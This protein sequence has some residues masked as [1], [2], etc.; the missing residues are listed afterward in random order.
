MN[1]QIECPACQRRFQVNDDLTGKTVEC[2]ACDHRFAVTEDM[3][4]QERKK[5]YPG[6]Q[7]GEGLDHFGRAP[8]RDDV[9]VTFQT[10]QYTQGMDAEVVQPTSPIQIFASLVGVAI[11][12]VFGLFFLLATRDGGV[13]NDVDLL[14][15]F[16]LGGFISMIGCGLLVFGAKGW[17]GRAIGIAIALML[18]LLAIIWVSPVN[19]TPTTY[20]GLREPFKEAEKATVGSSEL[21]DVEEYLSDIGYAKVVDFINK[22]TDLEKGINGLDHVVAI[23]AH[24]VSDIAFNTLE[25]HLR[26]RLSLAPNIPIHNYKRNDIKDRL[27]VISGPM[28]NLEVVARACDEAGEVT[29]LTKRRLLDLSINLTS[30]AN[31]KP[32]EMEK[33]KNPEHEI[34]C[35]ANLGELDNIQ[36]DRRKGAVDRLAL[37]PDDMKKRYKSAIAQKLSEMVATESDEDLIKSAGSALQ[38]WGVG[39]ATIVKSVGKAVAEKLEDEQSIPKSIVEY[40]ILAKSDQALLA[41]DQQWAR[42]PTRWSDQYERLGSLGEDRLAFHIKNSPVELRNS[43]VDI[44]RRVGTEKSIPTLRS[45][46]TGANDGFDI[47]LKRAIESIQSR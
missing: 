39:E 2:G 23:Y 32:E 37:V 36:L 26:R 34:F 3:T 10:A 25:E 24:P 20:G 15:R 14:S 38:K 7:S 13:F 9:P 43:A 22:E 31:P 30:F 12:L 6:E 5:F 8:I 45:A 29:P 1:L 42:N 47:S 16:I 33:L 28:L 4:V 40:L 21:D 35:A 41:V 27:I 19:I 46:L 44:L 11:M 18:A 17:R